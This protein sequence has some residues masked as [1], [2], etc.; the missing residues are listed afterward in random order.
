MRNSKFYIYALCLIL[1]SVST[2]QCE[3]IT[4]A[5]K[6]YKNIQAINKELSKKYTA[7]LE[8]KQSIDTFIIQGKTDTITKTYFKAIID[9]FYVNKGI[10]LSLYKDSLMGANYSVKTDIV[11]NSLYSIKYMVRCDEK[12]I[13][14][15]NIIS[16]TDTVNINLPKP[17]LYGISDIGINHV[18]IGVLYQSKGKLGFTAKSNWFK[19]QQYYTAGITYKMF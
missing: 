1:I 17:H 6:S 10:I 11:A 4:K 19:D 8:S 7:L 2:Y 14:K 9:T 13:I 3:R 16:N 18:S 5:K 12:V 15:E